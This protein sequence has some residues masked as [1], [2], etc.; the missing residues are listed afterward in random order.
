MADM[1]RVPTTDDLMLD[2]HDFGGGGR[3]ALAAHATG[4]NGLVWR[5]WAALQHEMHLVAP[6]FRGHGGS[7][8]P[9]GVP[10]SWE[11]YAD[12][13]LAV[14]A[15]APWPSSD[16]DPARPIGIGHS[17]GGAALLLAEIRQ[18]RTFAGL[19]L[20]EPITFPPEIRST[21]GD[22]E[23]PLAAGA[24]RRRVRFPSR[25]EAAATYRSKPPLNVFADASMDA[26]VEGGFVGDP[27]GSVSLACRPGDE[28]LVYEQASTCAAFEQ[29]G[30]VT[31]PVVVAH[32][33]RAQGPPAAIA[34]LL[35]T[36]LP[37]GRTAA[38][39]DL[40]HFGPM[41]APARLAADVAAFARSL[42]S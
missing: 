21:M 7:T 19:W 10:Y 11:R 29:A 31:C 15:A 2:V 34:P 5:P 22:A 20:Y 35:A 4:F 39:E 17:M 30:D 26:Y 6:D 9:A 12:D 3:P 37:E 42:P 16:Q 28:A 33:A 36:R 41:E 8:C 14:L 18:P 1:L 13:V 38:Y 27:D 23:N 25:A 24:R 32:G 40:G